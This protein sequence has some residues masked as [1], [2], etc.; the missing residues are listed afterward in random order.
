MNIGY[1]FIEVVMMLKS[2]TP[3]TK[4]NCIEETRENN[5]S[6][7]LDSFLAKTDYVNSGG[8]FTRDEMN[9]R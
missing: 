6:V 3:S 5:L 4:E 7:R 9:E 1:T 2:I 8:S